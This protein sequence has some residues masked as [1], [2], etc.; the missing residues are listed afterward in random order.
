[1]IEEPIVKFSI[2]L[3]RRL[4][5]ELEQ[6]CSTRRGVTKTGI[7][8]A[9]LDEYLF[10]KGEDKRDAEIGRHLNRVERRVKSIERGNE[11]LGETISIFIRAWLTNTM[12][13]PL[14]QKEAAEAQVGRRYRNFLNVLAERL[15]SGRCL[16]DDLPQDVFHDPHPQEFFKEEDAL[17]I[18]QEIN[19]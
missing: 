2:R 9:A 12:E 19:R 6:I 11:I 3:P 14:S 17:E 7:I 1:M 15:Q 13:V 18:E 10:P 5:A 8:Q 16:F 4:N